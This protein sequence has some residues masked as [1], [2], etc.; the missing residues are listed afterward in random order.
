M[1][2]FYDADGTEMVAAIGRAVGR[3]RIFAIGFPWRLAGLARP[4][5]P[6]IRELHEMRYLWRKAIRLDNR[7]LIEFLGEEQRTPIDAA[8]KATL[9]SLGCLPQADTAFMREPWLRSAGGGQ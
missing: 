6:L 8:V 5:V 7:H 3:P 2:G 1:D 9:R 4:F